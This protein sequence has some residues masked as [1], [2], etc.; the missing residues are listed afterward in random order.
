MKL[1]FSLIGAIL[2]LMPVLIVVSLIFSFKDF[3]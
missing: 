2:E 1:I 3:L